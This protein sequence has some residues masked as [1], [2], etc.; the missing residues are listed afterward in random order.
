MFHRQTDRLREAFPA[1]DRRPKVPEE[2]A[3]EPRAGRCRFRDLGGS[4][5]DGRRWRRGRVWGAWFEV[6]V[7]EL[8]LAAADVAECGGNDDPTFDRREILTRPRR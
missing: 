8:E 2:G 4:G 1:A 7:V 3:R 5:T 6:A